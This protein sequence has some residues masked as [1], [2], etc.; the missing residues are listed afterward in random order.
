V[1]LENAQGWTRHQWKPRTNL[2]TTLRKGESVL[3]TTGEES[4]LYTRSTECRGVKVV[5]GRP[6]SGTRSSSNG[7][8]PIRSAPHQTLDRKATCQEQKAQYPKNARQLLPRVLTRTCTR[9]LCYVLPLYVTIMTY[10]SL[11]ETLGP[12]DLHQIFDEG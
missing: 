3:V 12:V 11:F 2:R 8:N 10:I 1:K 9:S 6:G 4:S 5:A 7:L